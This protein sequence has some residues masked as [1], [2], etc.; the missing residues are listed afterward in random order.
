[1][2]GSKPGGSM[3]SPSI[4]AEQRQPPAP[5]PHNT[6]SYHAQQLRDTGCSVRIC[7][8]TQMGLVLLRR[9]EDVLREKQAG[10][11]PELPLHHLT[12]VLEGR[13]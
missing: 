7:V 12:G 11:E 5:G 10:A 9:W 8:R 2:A 6:C 4:N 3:A 13:L 1:M